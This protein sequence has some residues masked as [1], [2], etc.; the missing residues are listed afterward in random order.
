MYLSSIYSKDG[1][2]KEMRFPGAEVLRSAAALGLWGRLRSSRR[3]AA[4]APETQLP[5]HLCL[6]S[7]SVRHQAPSHSGTAAQKPGSRKRNCG[8]NSW[9]EISGFSRLSSTAAEGWIRNKKVRMKQPGPE[10]ST[11]CKAAV[12]DQGRAT[13]HLGA[14]RLWCQEEIRGLRML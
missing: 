7:F 13:G 5:W 11:V 4:P 3:S 14:R 9:G 2:A 8:A 10:S 1:K 6:V 12:C